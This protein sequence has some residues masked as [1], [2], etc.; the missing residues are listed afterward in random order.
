MSTDGGLRPM[1]RQRLRGFMWVP[2]ETPISGGGVPDHHWA[3]DGISGWNEYKR[4]Q[5]YK[6]K[7]RPEQIGWHL[8]YAR[9]GGRSFIIVRHLNNVTD[10]LYIY[11]GALAGELKLRGLK[12][13][14]FILHHVG[15]PSAWDW[16]G[17]AKALLA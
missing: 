9:H 17:I 13:R 14:S 7:F 1:F 8:S 3:K 16:E 11:P 4:A 15:S 6:I 5:G 10:D 2:V 12:E